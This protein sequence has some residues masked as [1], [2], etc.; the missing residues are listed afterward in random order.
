MRVIGPLGLGGL[1]ATTSPETA[2]YLRTL[3]QNRQ[4][5]WQS[6]VTNRLLLEA[7]LGSYVAAWGPFEA[8]GNPRAVS[9][10]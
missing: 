5:T 7:G 4:V 3:V 8:P 9:S 2:G 10:A 6:P 1:T